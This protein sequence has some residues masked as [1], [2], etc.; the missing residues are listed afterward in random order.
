MNARM[1]PRINSRRTTMAEAD[2]AINCDEF[3]PLDA[4][5]MPGQRVQDLQ[6]I[7]T[8]VSAELSPCSFIER[9]L[10][11]DF[12]LQLC[13][14]D[15]FRM[16][17]ACI[18]DELIARLSEEDEDAHGSS[19]TP[20][21]VMKQLGKVFA[22]HLPL[23]QLATQLEHSVACERD[24]IMH[25]FDERRLHGLKAALAAIEARAKGDRLTPTC[26]EGKELNVEDR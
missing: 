19:V 12:A 24:R 7:I 21:A 20:A 26:E 13:W 16:A 14:G 1:S 17:R 23:I 4:I 11:R 9:M 18:V 8:A 15:Y 10:A 25:L 5:T 22:D 3:G 6:R 2:Y